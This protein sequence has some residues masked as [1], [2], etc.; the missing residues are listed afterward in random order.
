MVWGQENKVV[1]DFLIAMG[2]IV[3][4]VVS[5]ISFNVLRSNLPQT[6]KNCKFVMDDSPVFD[7]ED[8]ILSPEKAEVVLSGHLGKNVTFIEPFFESCGVAYRFSASDTQ[9]L[10][11]TNGEIYDYVEICGNEGFIE[12][13]KKSTEVIITHGNTTGS[14]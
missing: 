10:V 2:I 3:F 12:K 14:S 6:L 13:A 4:I 1:K 11:C 9:Y 5:V 8:D 7:Y